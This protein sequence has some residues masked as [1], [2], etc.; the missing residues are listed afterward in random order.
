MVF[1]MAMVADKKPLA[2]TPYLKKGWNRALSPTIGCSIRLWLDPFARAK[3]SLLLKM[4]GHSER[5]LA[6]ETV[7]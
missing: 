6:G 5:E 1:V 7:D 2:S 3:S 4:H